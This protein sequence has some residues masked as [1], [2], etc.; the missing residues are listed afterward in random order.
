MSSY[1]KMLDK[2]YETKR[3]RELVNAPVDALAGVAKGDAE[4]LARAFGIKTIG[5]L[6]KNKYFAAA[7][8]ITDV[9]TR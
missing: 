9:A 7:R 2:A 8:E 5:D 3:P 1:E 6:A 4:L